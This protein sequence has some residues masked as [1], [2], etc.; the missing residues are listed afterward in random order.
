[1]AENV[2]EMERSIF[3]KEEIK[4]RYAMQAV[5]SLVLEYGLG[6]KIML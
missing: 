5:F 1:M 4:G 6:I 2:Q 3:R